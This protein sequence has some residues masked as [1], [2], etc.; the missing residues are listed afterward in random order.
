MKPGLESQTSVM[1]CTGR[2]LAHGAP[3]AAGFSDPTALP[4]LPAEAQARVARIRSG[5]GPGSLRTRLSDVHLSGLSR[6]MVIRTL[7]I[8]EAVREAGAP[9]LVILGAGLDGRAWRMDALRDVRVFEV[10]HPDTQRQKR[11]RAAALTPTAR[12][13]AFVP[14]DFAQKNDL[15]AA[16]AA[17]GHDP[18]LP[19]TWI[20]EGVV[21]Y[22]A[23]PD[24]EATLQ[25]VQ[26]RSAPGSRLVVAYHRPAL[27]LRVL[28]PFLRRVGEPLRSAFTPEAMR[29]LLGRH[30]L[31]VRRDRSLAELGA[32]LNPTLARASRALRHLGIAVAD[33]A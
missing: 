13:I 15:D 11:A 21:M 18:A 8:D 26:R 2:A 7:A 23:Q 19:T 4:L 33:R 32:A 9:Q 27:M 24:V 25:V 29:A 10:D 30:G 22:L 20:W 5:R 14:V 31:T 12:A 1:V 28:G 3:W 17:S 6:S 16:L